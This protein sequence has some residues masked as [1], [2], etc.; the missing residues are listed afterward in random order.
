MGLYGWL[1]GPTEYD[2]VWGEFNDY[3]ERN[4]HEPE[5]AE[6]DR[7]SSALDAAAE[8]VPWWKR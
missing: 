8:R 3:V 5:P 4:G 1:F 2:V 6:Y 7:L